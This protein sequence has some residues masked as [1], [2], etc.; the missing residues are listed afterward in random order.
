VSSSIGLSSP[1]AVGKDQKESAGPPCPQTHA[2]SPRWQRHPKQLSV[3]SNSPKRSVAAISAPMDVGCGTGLST[4]AL[5]ELA[6]HIVGVD[7]SAAM[8]ALTSPDPHIT[9][10]VASAEHLP[11][12]GASFD[13]MTLSSVFHWLAGA[14]FLAQARHA[15]TPTG[16]LVIYDNYFLGQM[17]GQP[18]F[19]AWSRDSLRTRYPS[20]PRASVEFDADTCARSGFAFLGQEHYDTRVTF[21]PETLTNYLVTQSN[22]IA[23]VEGGR[24]SI[25]EVRQWLMESMAPLFGTRSEAQFLF[26]GPIWYLQ[27]AGRRTAPVP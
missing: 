11:T 20:P 24:E 23:A 7:A 16:H 6:T 26:A 18:A 19:H 2:A 14:A 25:T 21:S 5:K 1:W 4:I 22:V 15:L 27:N 8:L 3:S 13:I 17:E 12:C 9:Y 10:V